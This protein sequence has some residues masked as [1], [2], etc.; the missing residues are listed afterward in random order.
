MKEKYIRAADADFQHFEVLRSNRNKRYHAGEFLVEGVRSLK[1]AKACGW[2]IRSLIYPDAKLSDWANGYIAECGCDIN[3][4]LTPELMARLSGKTDP[5]EMMAIVAMKPDMAESG[6]DKIVASLPENPMIV[7][8]DRPSNRGNLGTL[9]RSADALGVSLLLT[10]GHSVDLYDPEVVVSA[11]GS[12]FKVP[13]MRISDN[14][15]LDALIE[16]LRRRYGD[17]TLLGTTAHRQHP[18]WGAPLAKSFMLMI[19]NETMGLSAAFKEKC[20]LLCTIPMAED[21][22]ATS[23]N[24]SCAATAMLYEAVRQRAGGQ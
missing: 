3:Y 9:I 12:F 6:V 15:V 2:E 16:R 1:E 4:R 13:A 5:S 11:M 10:T 21:S 8:F 24:V 14:R 20:D 17:F 18:I 23:F 22:Y 19:G 7:L